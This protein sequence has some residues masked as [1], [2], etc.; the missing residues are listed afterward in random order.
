MLR[1]VLALLLLGSTVPGQNILPP[2][3]A[4]PGNPTTPEKV[5]LGKALFWDEQ[6]S[7][8]RSVACGT[9]HVLS[10]G[11][12]D[13]RSAAA[14]H[15]GADGV[16]GTDD[17]VHGSPGVAQHAANG[18]L[19]PS[20]A[21]GLQ[22]QV[23]GRRA[24]SVINAA[25][26]TSLF[27]DGRAGD[28]F[29]DP[30]THAVVLPSGG[31]L[32]SQIAA[33]PVSSAEM[34]H[35]GRTWTDIASELPGLRPLALATNVPQALEQFLAG[36]TYDAVFAQVFGSPGVTPARIVFAIAAYERTLVS[37]QSPFDRYLAGLGTLT[38]QEALGLARFET[39]CAGCHT[40]LDPAVLGTGPVLDDFRN[41][42]VRPPA[43]DLG[44]GAVT[45]LAAD[46][47]TFRVP[48]LR[49][50]ALRGSYFHNGGQ[51]TLAQV[52]DFYAR[53]GDFADNRDPLVDAISGHIF[54]VDNLQL[55]AL[56]HALTDPRVAQELPPFDRP[57]LASEGPN[58]PV[59]FGTGTAGTGGLPPRITALGPA[60]LGNPALGV[61][62]ERLA[63][64]L[65]TALLLDTAGSATPTSV[66]GHE[67]HLAWS[68]ALQI[69]LTG[70]SLPAPDGRGYATAVFHL[71]ADPTLAGT[72][73][74]QWAA[75]D[76]NGPAGLASSD[77]LRLTVY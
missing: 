43:E 28:V 23:T 64:N 1:P 74:L 18:E 17:D 45:G 5:L 33:P 71:P 10:Q 20:A 19:V 4:P 59:A 61:G 8:S 55:Q 76:G 13:P 54:I 73:W 35:L 12:A 31:A 16:F 32:E 72:Y 7:S 25:W 53:G 70:L 24:P 49:N 9:C 3:P 27:V 21:F 14:L 37:D 38:N 62:V 51:Q 60:Y 6:L 50:V 47:G 34:G 41:V 2:P 46:R 39:F 63:P 36:R 30:V 48:G 66:L 57:R 22:P 68:P 11:G 77:A 69:L 75:L 26:A 42:G 29:L 40:D 65:F 56:L 52:V 67:L 44:R 15:P 58:M